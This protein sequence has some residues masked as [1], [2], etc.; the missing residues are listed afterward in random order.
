MA[1]IENLCELAALD[2]CGVAYYH[3]DIICEVFPE[4]IDELHTEASSIEIKTLVTKSKA[5]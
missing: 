4:G 2:H 5:T 1:G 3:P